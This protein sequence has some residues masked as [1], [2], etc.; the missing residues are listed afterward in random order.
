MDSS[1]RTLTIF[2]ATRSVSDG[3]HQGGATDDV[4]Q[5]TR[6][7]ASD[8]F[9]TAAVAAAEAS[10]AAV[11]GGGG[12]LTQPYRMLCELVTSPGELDRHFLRRVLISAIGLL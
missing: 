12:A 5:Q 10:S 8:P 9:T 1:Y 11:E 6:R 3:P 4:S 7:S 2:A